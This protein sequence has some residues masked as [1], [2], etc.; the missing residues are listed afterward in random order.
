M[1]AS[2]RLPFLWF[3]IIIFEVQFD[4]LISSSVNLAEES[5]ELRHFRDWLPPARTS[6]SVREMKLLEDDGCPV[7]VIPVTGG[8]VS[9]VIYSINSSGPLHNRG[10]G[11]VLSRICETF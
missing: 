3:L 6:L 11:G 10:F 8:Q 5:N 1:Q 7:L 4:V 2:W 9:I